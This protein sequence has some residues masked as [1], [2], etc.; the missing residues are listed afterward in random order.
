MI[1]VMMKKIRKYTMRA[2]AQI[3]DIRAVEPLI[4]ALND[5]DPD[6]RSE[7]IEA[8][9][10]IGDPRAFEPLMALLKKNLPVKSDR[11]P[12]W[13]YIINA[14]GALGDKRAAEPLFN[15]LKDDN[16]KKREL[17]LESLVTLKDPRAVE[18]L[19]E[20]LKI[21]DYFG[22]F[23]APQLLGYVDDARTIEP[24]IDVT[25]NDRG[26]GNRI[27]AAINLNRKNDKRATDFIINSFKRRN[28]DV[29]VASHDY[30]IR[31]G[32]PGTEEILIKTLNKD[33]HVHDI[34][35]QD[36]A[37]AMYKC[38]NKQLSEAGRI[39]MENRGIRYELEKDYSDNIF[40]SMPKWGEANLE[41]PVPNSN[42]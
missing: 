38:G 42:K 35:A 9:G 7:A 31:R 15:L 22:D 19:I 18:P 39:W 28:W 25:K 30:F 32:E 2:L 11:Q 37:M 29:I 24:L 1:K 23:I 34:I 6:V 20:A 40:T 27:L 33:W 26:Q 13:F 10:E 14:L 21:D 8:L 16:I 3:K 17:A 36:M 5:K 4:N 41:K 12:E